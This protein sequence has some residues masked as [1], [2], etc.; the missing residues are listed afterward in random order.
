M[1]K[2][3][4]LILSFIFSL[5]LFASDLIV[6]SDLDDTIK[7]TNVDN[8][9]TAVYNALFTQKVFKAMPEVFQTMET[10]TNGLYVLSNSFNLLRFNIFKL[11]RKSDINPLEVST[12]NMLRDKDGFKYKYEFITGKMDEL[13][14][15]AILIGDD[16]GKDPQV[17]DKVIKTHGEKV[18]AAYIHLIM[19]R[20]VPSTVTPYITSFDIALN[21]YKEQRM[22]LSQVEN[23][24]LEILEAEDFEKVIPKYAYCP[25]DNKYWSKFKFSELKNMIDSI[26]AKIISF[27]QNRE[28]KQ[29]N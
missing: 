17:Y 23:L 8:V 15:N 10:Y 3:L 4:V 21:E 20:E 25:T 14:S 22:N 26:S 28:L 27:C 2:K 24:G 9:P 7:Q 6:I 19:N 12:R 18:K 16:H 11:L 1:A 29:K 5:N 13:N